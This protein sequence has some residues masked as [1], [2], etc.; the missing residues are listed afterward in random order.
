MQ[1]STCALIAA[2]ILAAGCT[3]VGTHIGAA[4]GR[5]NPWT[6]PGVVRLAEGEEPNT[7]IRMFSNQASADDVTALLF[8]PFFRFDER[9]RP[10]PGLVTQ[11]PTTENG[12]ISKDG[13]E[14]TF[15]LRSGVLWSDGAPFTAQDVVFTWHAIVDGNNPVT[16]TAGFDKIKTIRTDNPHQVTFILKEPNAGVVYFFSEGSFPPLPAH[17]LK[18]YKSINN[19]PYDA[20]PVGDGPF[21]LKQ[22]L[23]GSDI[24]FAPNERYWRGKPKVAEVDLKIIPNTNT[25]VDQVRTHEIDVLGSVSKPLVLQLKGL[26]GVRLV[27]QL[28]AN[29]RHLDFNCRSPILREV[30][31]RRAIA[32]A[33]DIDKII[34]DVYGGYGVRGAT[35]IP[36]FSW[37]ANDLEP[38]PYDVE[39][40]KKL[41]DDA[42]WN[43]GP[44]GIRARNGQRLELTISSATG[45][46]PNANAEQIMAQELRAV[47]IDLRIKNYQGAV[48]FA[49]E[50][51]LYGGR[52]DMAWIVDTE[53]T[54]PDSFA[55]W[56]CDFWP[57]HGANT[58]FYCNRRVDALM[59]DAQL[60]YDR[61]RRKHDY[62]EAWKILL[63]EAPSVIIYWDDSVTALNADLKNYK[64]SPVITDFWN[65][66]EWQI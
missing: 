9:M 24:I 43:A 41:L 66:W 51:P 27:K 30:N 52:Y 12:L 29:Y 34:H 59:R 31:V 11:F 7:L 60:R 8:E 6:V 33:I 57:H 20:N 56:G 5:A 46:M 14:I 28:S 63:D 23:H 19:I 3:K 2:A 38:V 50:G 40:A 25:Q 21:K 44:E 39:A 17:L 53:G 65:A 58:D 42:G 32:R 45:N 1:K 18:S 4:P 15:K 26:P 10:V 61:Q 22:W 36:P 37:A 35:D 49:P 48:L 16:Y 55:K 62:Y 54:D 64:P 13:L 47:G